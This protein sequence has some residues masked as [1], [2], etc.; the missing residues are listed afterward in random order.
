[1]FNIQKR[2]SM[3][4]PEINAIDYRVVYRIE[5]DIVIIVAIKHR[6]DVYDE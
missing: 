2:L 4:M 5:N 3:M 6:K 1:M